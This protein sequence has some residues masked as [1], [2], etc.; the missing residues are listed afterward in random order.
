MT[1]QLGHRG[2][3]S[4]EPAALY[5]YVHEDADCCERR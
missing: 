2:V 1:V 5:T 4:N 3:D